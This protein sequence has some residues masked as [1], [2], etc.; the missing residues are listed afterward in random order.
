[1]LWGVDALGRTY[2]AW[3]DSHVVIVSDGATQHRLV[4]PNSREPLTPEEKAL[5]ANTLEKFE[6]YSLKQGLTLS[7]PRPAVPEFRPQLDGLVSEMN[8]GIAIVRSRRC[9]SMPDWRAPGGTPAPAADSSAR[10]TLVER[11]DAEGRRLRPFTLGPD[12]TLMVLRGDTAWVRQRGK[13][14]DRIVEMV[15]GR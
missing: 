7:G 1:V 2:A 8:G 3:N 6:S 10:C 12:D 4:L 13:T 14:G 9:A 11:F 15:M 5:A